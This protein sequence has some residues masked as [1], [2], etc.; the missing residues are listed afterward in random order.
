VW[1][2]AVDLP[3]GDAGTAARVLLVSGNGVVI[4]S[5]MGGALVSGARSPTPRPR[6]L[7]YR[8]GQALVTLRQQ[9]GGSYQV[10]VAA[11]A[12]GLG[13]GAMPIIAAS[14]ELGA[15]EFADSLSCSHRGRR[16]IC[17]G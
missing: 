6:S 12:V 15:T 16:I 17:H 5:A 3:A 14:L 13:T 9:P 7:R 1:R 8:S 2:G 4:D 10:R 11:R